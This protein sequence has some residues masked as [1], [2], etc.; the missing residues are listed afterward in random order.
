VKGVTVIGHGSSNA[1]AI[2]NAVRVAMELVRGGVNEKIEHELSMI[3][4]PVEA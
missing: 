3:P 2:K 1:L 4:V